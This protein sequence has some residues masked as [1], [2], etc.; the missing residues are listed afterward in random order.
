[1]DAVNSTITGLV[2]CLL[3]IFPL[4]SAATNDAGESIMQRGLI[5]DDYYAA[6]KSWMIC[7]SPVAKSISRPTSAT[8]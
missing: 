7:A 1:M 5:D 2:L 8:T 6:A 3:L 4:S